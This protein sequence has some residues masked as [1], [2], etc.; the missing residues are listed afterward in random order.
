[1]SLSSTAWIVFSMLCMSPVYHASHEHLL[2]LRHAFMAPD[3]G[4]LV[5]PRAGG[6]TLT[7]KGGS[8]QSSQKLDDRTL[9]KF[10]KE[11]TAMGRASWKFAWAM[12][13]TAEE[14][15]KGKTHEVGQAYFE[16]ENRKY[17]L[18]DAPGHRGYVPSMIAGAA[19]AEVAVL[20]IS[21]RT[22]EFEAGFEK[23]GQT[24][25]HAILIRSTGVRHLIVAVNKMDECSWSKERYDDIVGKLQ[26]F[27]KSIG[28]GLSEVVFLPLDGLHGVNLKS[29][30]GPDVCSWYDGPSLIEA[31]DTVKLVKSQPSLPVRFQ[32]S[33]AYRETDVY[34]LGKLE[35]GVIRAGE[36]LLLLPDNSVITI[37]QIFFES[38][39]VEESSAGDILRLKVLPCEQ[40]G[41]EVKV[42]ILDCKSIIAAGYS[43]MFHC[44]SIA[45]D[46][47]W[48]SVI[49][50]IDKQLGEVKRPFVRR[51]QSAVLRLEF[52]SEICVETYKDFSQLGRFVL[53]EDGLTIGIG[54]VLNLL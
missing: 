19:L 43:C 40:R 8:D 5:R 37:T 33:C 42:N 2:S 26:P 11:S 28:Y 22:G 25:E 12:D 53:R 41:I 23:G 52:S 17:T 13:L 3:R 15:E 6:N 4:H 29:R 35:C 38:T 21:A 32:V 51:G 54:I 50:V 9:D 34:L 36:E 27:F 39:S 16:S 7:L 1:M 30:M 45:T 18:L 24:R 46:C 14:R 10:T 20:I 49:S 47:T 48:E 31:L 44:H